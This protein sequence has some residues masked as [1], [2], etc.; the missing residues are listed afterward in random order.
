MLIRTNTVIDFSRLQVLV[1][2][3]ICMQQKMGIKSLD[4]KLNDTTQ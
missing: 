1:I 4:I 3:C 2:T